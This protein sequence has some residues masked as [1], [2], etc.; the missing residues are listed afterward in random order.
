M[1]FTYALSSHKKVNSGQEFGSVWFTVI[2]SAPRTVS[3]I[4]EANCL[5]S[6]C[7]L[8]K[9]LIINEVICV[10]VLC[11]SCHIETPQHILATIIVFFIFLKVKCR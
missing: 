6:S 11:L 3:G 5:K 2:F 10:Q 1:Y 8:N 9:S 7:G 4:L